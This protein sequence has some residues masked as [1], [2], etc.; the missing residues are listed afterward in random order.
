[1]LSSFQLTYAAVEGTIEVYVNDSSLP[2]ELIELDGETW[3][4]IDEDTTNGWSYDETYSLIYFH[5][6]AVPPR[7]ATIKIDYE[8]VPGSLSNV[9]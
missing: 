8:V 3:V 2:G 6:D 1:M 5:G 7:E 9:D 4:Q